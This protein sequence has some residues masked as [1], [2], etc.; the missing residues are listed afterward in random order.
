MDR[1][2]V[3]K[4][5][6]VERRGDRGEGTRDRSTRSAASRL[7]KRARDAKNRSPDCGPRRRYA[8]ENHRERPSRGRKRRM[9]AFLSARHRNVTATESQRARPEAAMM[10]HGSRRGHAGGGQNIESDFEP[11]PS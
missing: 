2:E 7:R 3:R 10:L 5:L 4:D 8:T 1:K 9:G 11:P 6:D